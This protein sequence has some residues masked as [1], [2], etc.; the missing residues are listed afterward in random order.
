VKNYSQKFGFAVDLC[1]FIGVRGL[2]RNWRRFEF[3]LFE[4]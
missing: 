4:V 1:R 2:R 3:E